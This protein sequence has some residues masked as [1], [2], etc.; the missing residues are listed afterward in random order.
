MPVIDLCG[1]RIGSEIG[2]LAMIAQVGVS[3]SGRAGCVNAT[4]S[5]A[6][7]T[8]E[9]PVTPRVVRILFLA[10]T[11]LGFDLPFRPRIV[12]RRRGHDFF[13]SFRA[14]LAPALRGEVDLV[15]H[16]GD[17]LFRTR[18]P[19]VLVQMAMEPLAQVAN[20]GVPVFLVPGNHES[21]RIPR[22]LWTVHPNIHIF[23]EPRT[24]RLS[25]PAGTVALAG[26]PFRRDARDVFAELVSQTGYRDLAGADIRILCLH[27]TVEGAQVGVSDYTFRYGRDVIRDRDIPGDFCAV[28]S[29]HIHR[30]QKLTRD[31]SGRPMAAPVVYA[32][33]VERTSFAE[34]CEEKDYVILEVA[35]SADHRG[36]LLSTAF[37]P[38]P[39]RPMISL[40]IAPDGLGPEALTEHVKKLLAGVDPDAVVRLQLGGNL[41]S[42][43]QGAL[44]ATNIRALA[45]PTMNVSVG[46]RRTARMAGRGEAPF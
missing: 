20:R 29:G 31:L 16:G 38:L 43:A 1:Y 18:V 7:S 15:V 36:R 28:L 44:S 14:A 33:S 35:P 11:H 22:Q 2:L 26:F 41:S 30:S 19:E 42:E 23:H 45:P 13:A 24:F 46:Y 3:N 27:Q 6:P 8:N 32:G 12:R 40:A 37:V 9:A 5:H 25:L 4:C 34:R 10:D 21:G 39:A 17:L